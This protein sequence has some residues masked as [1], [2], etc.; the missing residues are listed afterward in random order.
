[1]KVVS[2]REHQSTYNAGQT[3]TLESVMDTIEQTNEPVVLTYNNKPVAA[4]VPIADYEA[5]N[6]WRGRE[7]LQREIG[8][9]SFER[10]RS[11]FLRLKPELLE[12]HLGH[13]VAIHD[14][15]IIDSD[16]DSLA[17]TL[18]IA[19]KE[20]TPIYIQLVSPEPRTAEISSPEEV[21]HV[22]RI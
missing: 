13:Y 10:E 6:H 12:S 19:Q 14:G 21:W 16:L 18:R 1:M 9:E 4:V 15:Q 17:L 3:P 5:F 11:A 20:I 2:I 7:S 22:D 8:D